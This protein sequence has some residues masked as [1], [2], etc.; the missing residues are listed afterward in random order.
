MR[1]ESMYQDGKLL[2]RSDEVLSAPT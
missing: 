1:R 2:K